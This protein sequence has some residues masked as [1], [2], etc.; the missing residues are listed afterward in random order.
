MTFVRLQ[1][2]HDPST[3]RPALKKRAQE[4]A[5][6]SGREDNPAADSRPRIP[7]NPCATAFSVIP[8]EVE[9]PW[10]PFSLTQPDETK[11]NIDI[12]LFSA[13]F[14]CPPDRSGGTVAI[15]QPNPAR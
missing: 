10:Q 6:R 11:L 2:C 15:L 4:N 5:G 13:A 14:S 1:G 3:T 12:A 9:G 8:T 7:A